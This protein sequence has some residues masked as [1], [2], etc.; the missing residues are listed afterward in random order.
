[1]TGRQR[2]Q[3]AD[4]A[5]T[6]AAVEELRERGY[7]G[8]T[9][10]GVI[11]RAGISSATLYRRFPTKQALVVATLQTVS[12]GPSSADTGT[13]AGDLAD[14][15]K[16]IAGAIAARDDLFAVLAVEVQFDDELRA[17]SRAAFVEPRLRQVGELLD[18]A[19]ARG[20]LDSRP[21]PDVVLSLVT[22]PIS[23]RAFS[24]GE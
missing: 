14:L 7:R 9:M 15:A 23:H 24:L 22:G 8:L 3:A 16:R 2:S 4:D 13:L 21:A 12:A 10:S 6:A 17:V 1:M 11:E 5:I 20:E 19:V 18:R